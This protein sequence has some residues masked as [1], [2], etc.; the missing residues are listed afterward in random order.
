M[1]GNK[2]SRITKQTAA[3]RAAHRVTLG[4]PSVRIIS[5][6]KELAKLHVIAMESLNRIIDSSGNFVDWMNVLHRIYIGAVSLERHFKDNPDA[7]YVFNRAHAVCSI[8]KLR[9]HQTGEF[10]I[11]IRE[12]DTITNALALTDT[13]SR[14]MTLSEITLVH[15]HVER[16]FDEMT[17]QNQKAYPKIIGEAGRAQDIVDVLASEYREV[18]DQP[19]P[20]LETA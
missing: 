11:L 20:E 12:L 8:I 10:G 2:K 19:V 17:K 1:A 3:K 16:Y 18:K 13:M 14:M 5:P 6:S 15:R 9:T 7:N 4:P